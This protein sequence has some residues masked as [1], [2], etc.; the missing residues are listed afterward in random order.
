MAA[1]K[2]EQVLLRHSL[3]DKE[4]QLVF[5]I[6]LCLFS[7]LIPFSSLVKILYL[8]QSLM[9]PPLVSLLSAHHLSLSALLGL[10]VN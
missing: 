5:H 7:C 2:L 6:Y 1:I 4:E 9:F 8:I 10:S 3:R